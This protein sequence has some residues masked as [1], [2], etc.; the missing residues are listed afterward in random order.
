MSKRFP[1]V[2]ADGLHWRLLED[3]E[4]IPSRDT[5]MFSYDPCVPSP[6]SIIDTL[7][8]HPGQMGAI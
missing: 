3:V 2:S 7:S 8:L 6:C 4:R 5:S 1:A